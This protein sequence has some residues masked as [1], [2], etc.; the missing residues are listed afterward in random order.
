[1][2]REIEENNQQCLGGEK[3][4]KIREIENYFARFTVKSNYSD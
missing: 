1:L 3:I 2:H 4:V